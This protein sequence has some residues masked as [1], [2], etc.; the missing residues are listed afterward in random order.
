MKEWTTS[1]TEVR[2]GNLTTRGHSQV[3]LIESA[4]FE[5]TI[6][7][8]LR[9]E[10]PSAVEKDLLRAILVAHVSHGI[11][12]QST[13][14]VRMAA[15]SRAG[16][17]NAL[18]AG[19]STGAGPFHQGGL[20][21]TMDELKVLGPLGQ[22][23]L[24]NLIEARIAAKETVFGYGHRFH[25]KGDPRAKALINLARA[26]NYDGVHL[27]AA[28]HVESLLFELKGIRMN[29]E[30]AG[31]ALLL[32]MG[33]DPMIA[34]L[35]IILGRSPMFAAAYSERLNDS[36]SPFPKIRVFDVAK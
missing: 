17:F 1:I 16:F 25:K 26:H 21:A 36:P 20:K 33:F 7:L 18:I 11:T 9:G 12:G 27:R 22:S 31:G 19:F 6:F 2:N 3:A 35:F 10:L 28:I 15:D 14:A 8:L 24:R 29:I 4:A 13:L 34:H 5:D 23:E 30:A 32:D